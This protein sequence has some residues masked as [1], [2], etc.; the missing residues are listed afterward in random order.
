MKQM[1]RDMPDQSLNKI[2]L[3]TNIPTPYRKAQVKHWEMEGQYDITVYYCAQREQGRY[4]KFGENDGL[5]EVFL[6]GFHFKTFHFN[7]GILRVL[8]SK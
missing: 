6:R 7:P 3:I 4:W 5:R 2:A 1:V 8:I